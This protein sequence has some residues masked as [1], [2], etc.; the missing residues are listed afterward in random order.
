[1]PTQAQYLLSEAVKDHAF[2]LETERG[3]ASRRNQA[4]L[5]QRL[6]AASKLLEWLSTALTSREAGSTE[7]SNVVD[8]SIALGTD[9]GRSHL[10]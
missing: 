6:A 1:M 9:Q 2:E 5:D 7:K 4:A 3:S 10:R 8:L